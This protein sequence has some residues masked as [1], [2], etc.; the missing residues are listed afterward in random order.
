MDAFLDRESIHPF[1]SAKSGLGINTEGGAVG[2]GA[3]R[4]VTG[5][6]VIGGTWLTRGGGGGWVSAGVAGG[7]CVGAGIFTS[8]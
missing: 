2:G 4:E 3:G 6:T 8:G 7:S 1:A 5:G